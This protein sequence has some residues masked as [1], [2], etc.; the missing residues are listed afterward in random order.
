MSDDASAEARDPTMVRGLPVGSVVTVRDGA[1]A[2]VT[3]NPG[4]GGWLLVT[5]VECPDDPSR[6]GTDDMVFC[7][8]VVNIIR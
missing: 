7:I 4:D 6:V 3:G 1:T 2:V 8:D 5:V